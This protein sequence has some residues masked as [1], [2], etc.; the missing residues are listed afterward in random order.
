MEGPEAD[1]HPLR[2]EPLLEAAPRCHQHLAPVLED[3]A[4]LQFGVGAVVGRNRVRLDGD[5][6]LE[7]RRGERRGEDEDPTPRGLGDPLRRHRVRNIIDVNGLLLDGRV[8]RQRHGGEAEADPGNDVFVQHHGRR[9][10]RGLARKVLLPH[11]LELIELGRVHQVDL[12]FEHAIHAGAGFRQGALEALA[13][14]AGLRRDL[15]LTR[16]G[17]G[18]VGMH[19]GDPAASMG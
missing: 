3:V 4:G 10:R 7:V 19:H 2:L 16:V 8:P 11:Q 9:P 14:G 13:H 1:F 12:G 6:G 5:A 17:G 15:G 18:R